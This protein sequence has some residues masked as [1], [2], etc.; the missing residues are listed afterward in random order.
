[1]KIKKHSILLFNHCKRLIYL[2][3]SLTLPSFLLTTAISV[4]VAFAED[5]M[6]AENQNSEL[7]TDKRAKA[8]LTEM[9]VVSKKL[10]KVSDKPK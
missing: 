3:L 10:G 4:N 2:G 5:E 8:T 9:A 7:I 6:V 1:M